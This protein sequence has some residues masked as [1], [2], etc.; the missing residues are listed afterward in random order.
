LTRSA[1]VWAPEALDKLTGLW[2]AAAPQLRA[3]ITLSSNVIDHELRHDPIIKG[4]HHAE[5]LFSLDASPL[6]AF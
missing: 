5:G 2:T 1:V 4:R 3:A 6:R